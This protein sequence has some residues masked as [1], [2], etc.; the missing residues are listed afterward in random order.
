MKVIVS[1]CWSNLAY[2]VGMSTHSWSDAFSPTIS[3]AAWISFW[4]MVAPRR[5]VSR[6]RKAEVR[7]SISLSES[8][9]R[10]HVVTHIHVTLTGEYSA[11]FYL[12][13]NYPKCPPPQK[14]KKIS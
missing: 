2:S 12:S 9:V 1:E 3:I 8:E 4:S 7:Q 13:K 14:K 11:Q 5:P 6:E 10:G